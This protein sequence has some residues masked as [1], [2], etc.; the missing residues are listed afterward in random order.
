MKTTLTKCYAQ[1]HNAFPIEYLN[2]LRSQILSCPYLAASQLSDCFAKTKG[3]SVIF[4]RSSIG[5]LEQH[6]PFFKDYLEIALKQACNAFY[7]N[8]LV[9]ENGTGVEPHVDC[10]ISAYDMIFTI[11]NLVSVLYVQVPQD[12]SGGELVLQTN[13]HQIGAIQ[14]QTNTLVYFRGDLLHSV[15]KVK[16]SH[17]RISLICEQYKLSETRLE[18]IPDFAIKSGAYQHYNSQF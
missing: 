18:P 2:D 9:L 3:F 8:A 13:E 7:L 6:F 17:P 10:S 5:K 4:K 16:G 12:L 15:N 11:P 14:P 1:R